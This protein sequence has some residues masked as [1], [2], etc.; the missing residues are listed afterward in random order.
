[1]RIDQFLPSLSTKDAIGNE[2]RIIQSFLREWGYKS[3]IFAVEGSPDSKDQYLPYRKHKKSDVMI[4]HHSIGSDIV[5]YVKKVNGKKVLIYHNITPAHYFWDVNKELAN[6]LDLG[7]RQLAEM[8]E[9]FDLCL[10]DSEYNMEELEQLN[11]SN[12]KIS[13][14]LIDYSQYSLPANEA[15]LSKYKDDGYTNLLF[16]GKIAPHKGQGNLIKA[17]NYY[18]KFINEKSRLF[19]VGNSRGSGNYLMDIKKIAKDNSLDNII[20]D[21]HVSQNKLISYYKLADLFI[22]LSQHEGFCVPLIEGM[23]FKVPIMAYKSTAV[24][25]TLND[26]SLVFDTRNYL[27]IAEL[28]NYTVKNDSLRN[29][30]IN[31]QLVRLKDFELPSTSKKLK[32]LLETVL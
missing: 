13:P 19:L 24:P 2:V 30:I 25:W 10:A 32:Q 16:V 29:D 31:N 23:F 12:C 18:N 1:M 7:R 14:F 28:I 5:D 3:D 26:S 9:T 4:Y 15:L 8:S 27:E 11:Y 6:L 21:D 20:I 22:C 17:F